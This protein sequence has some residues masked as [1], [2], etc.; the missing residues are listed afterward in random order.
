MTRKFLTAA[1]L[2]LVSSAA[3]HAQSGKLT[4]YTSQPDRIAAETV[5]T[6]NKQHP[7]VT[8]EAFRSGTTEIMNKLAAEFLAGD[9][10]PDVLF[11]ADAV[12]MEGLKAEG[13]LQAYPDADVSTFPATAYDRDKTYFGSK[14]ITT[15]IV[16]NT[17]A[18]RPQS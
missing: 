14:L 11:I 7:T 1:L 12:T 6:F 15:G 10:K 2:A 17:A 13:R 3:A 5:A 16:Y 8:V 18:P 9:P 4:L